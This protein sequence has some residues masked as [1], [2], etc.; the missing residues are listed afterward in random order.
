MVLCSQLHKGVDLAYFN[1]FLGLQYVVF[2][3][4]KMMIPNDFG[5]IFSYRAWNHEP[6]EG[7]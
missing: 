6:D 1:W 3:Q 4:Y 5:V 2:Q 7:T